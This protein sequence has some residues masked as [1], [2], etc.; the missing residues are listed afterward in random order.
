M[1]KFDISDKILESWQKIVDLMAS[2][3]NVPSAIITHVERPQIEIIKASKNPE[4]P[5]REGQKANL[6]NHYCEQV[7]KTGTHFQL[8]NAL[9][10]PNWQNAPEVQYDIISYLGYPIYLPDGEIFGTI[11]VLDSKENSYDDLYKDLLMQF[12]QVV[13]NHL[14]SLFEREQL[15]QANKTKSLLFSIVSHDIRSPLHP[16]LGFSDMLYKNADKYDAARISQLADYIHQAS[17]NVYRLVESLFD[18][19]RSQSEDFQIK[20]ERVN[21]LDII[22][23]TL[24]LYKFEMEKKNIKIID[25][26]EAFYIRADK[27][28]F[29]TIMRNI[30]SNAFKFTHENG[31][32]R[33]E[34]ERYNDKWVK[35][36][37]IDFGKGMSPSIVDAIMNNHQIT[38]GS[39]TKGEKGSGVGLMISKEF[40]EKNNG[41]LEIESIPDKGTSFRI[42]LPHSS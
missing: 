32:I 22:Q 20:P 31:K 11:C 37:I 28:M 17:H 1:N 25:Q 27:M 3:V 29:S 13:E 19:A 12:K 39:G 30:I 33:V 38:A 24:E 16:I 6:T 2:L 14:S 23:E 41:S 4:N 34:T 36:S 26:I 8:N 42:F 21:V 18:W 9:K 5:Y 15:E 7:I 10:S 40:I 35:I